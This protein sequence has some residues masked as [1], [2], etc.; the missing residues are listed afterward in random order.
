MR[1]VMK[2]AAAAIVLGSAL[3][4]VV[5]AQEAGIKVG[6]DAPAAAVELLDGTKVD[7]ATYYTGKPV[8]IEFWATW[9]PLCKKLEPSLE[10]ARVK[11]AG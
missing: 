9:C 10:A 7:L 11:Y 2:L 4:R 8:V 1:S 3:P 6:A 5:H